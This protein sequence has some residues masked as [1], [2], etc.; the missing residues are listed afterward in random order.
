MVA[1]RPSD[2]ELID[3]PY[4]LPKNITLAVFSPVMV[5]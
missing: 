4:N 5:A 1:C 3:N 2:V